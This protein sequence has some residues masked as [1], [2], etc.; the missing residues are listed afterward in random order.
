[1]FGDHRRAKDLLVDSEQV[2]QAQAHRRWN[3]VLITGAVET[4]DQYRMYATVEN[5]AKVTC[6]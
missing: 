6:F 4:T 5:N 1:V 3:S 2:Q